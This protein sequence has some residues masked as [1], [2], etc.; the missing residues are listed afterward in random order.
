VRAKATAW[1][2]GVI[3]RNKWQNFNVCKSLKGQEHGSK[4]IDKK[5][6]QKIATST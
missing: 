2:V 1:N 6:K 5:K 4:L 3:I